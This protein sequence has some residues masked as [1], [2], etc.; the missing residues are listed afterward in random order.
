MVWP[1][2]K[3]GGWTEKGGYK[4]WT[5]TDK[6]LTLSNVSIQSLFVQE[7]IDTVTQPLDDSFAY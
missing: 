2:C 5:E 4:G 1:A 3:K 7:I 6:E